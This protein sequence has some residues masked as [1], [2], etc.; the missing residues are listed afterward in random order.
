MWTNRE[1]TRNQALNM[2]TATKT[3]T[4]NHQEGILHKLHKARFWMEF[5]TF[6]LATTLPPTSNI[7]EFRIP[8]SLHF[9]IVDSSI[10]IFPYLIHRC[11]PSQHTTDLLQ[12]I[13]KLRS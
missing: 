13:N 4:I 12:P 6:D 7:M 3:T 8:I 2:H 10:S 11:F 9:P 5:F 1:Q